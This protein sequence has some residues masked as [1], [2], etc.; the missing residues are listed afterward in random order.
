MVHVKCTQKFLYIVDIMLFI[1]TSNI[2][3]GR[4]R[5]VYI[6]RSV[7]CYARTI[8]FKLIK[9]RYLRTSGFARIPWS[10]DMWSPHRHICL[11]HN[12]QFGPGCVI[13]CDIKFGNNI[14]V[15]R[16]VVFI[17][18]D[19]HRFDI[20]GVPIWNCPRGDK[21]GVLVEDDVWIGH[22]A[23]VLSGVTIGRGAVVAAGAVVVSDVPTYAIVGGNP[24][25]VI[26]MRFSPYDQLVHEQRLTA[27][28][29]F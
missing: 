20:V 12:V 19:A 25:K 1:D 5:F 16:N 21:L 6:I 9:C 15:A 7:A 13:E 29:T 17:G 11:G 27:S 3:P 4:S 24:A 26:K 28:K 10:T 18:K 2:R 14:L 8:A 23:I 22:G